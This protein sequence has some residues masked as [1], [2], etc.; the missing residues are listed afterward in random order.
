MGYGRQCRSTGLSLRWVRDLFFPGQADAFET[1]SAEAEGVPPGCEGMSAYIGV[2][3]R[4]EDRGRNYGGFV[5]PV[6]WNISDYGRAHFFRAALETNAFGVRANLD[7][8]YSKG[9]M[10]PNVLHLCGGQSRSAL[11]A[12]ILADVTGT[13]VQ[14]YVNPECTA[15]GAAVQ[16]ACGVGLYDSLGEAAETFARKLVC[17]YPQKDAN[18][19]EIYA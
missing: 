13:A 4:G 10:R 2:G 6:P 18:Y 16:A 1:M 3:I 11:W 12:Q 5:F 19:P 17:Y 14:T 7:V 8:L 9:A 15:L